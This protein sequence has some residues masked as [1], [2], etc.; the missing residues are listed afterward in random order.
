MGNYAS[1]RQKVGYAEL[2]DSIPGSLVSE[3]DFELF[4]SL[5]RVE[6][7]RTISTLLHPS[8]SQLFF[9]VISGEVH[10]HITSLDV[11]NTSIPAVVFKPGETIHF[12]NMQL[13]N[14]NVSSPFDFGECLKNGNIK[15][16]LHFKSI[17]NSIA[18]VIGMD[19]TGLDEFLISASNNIHALN[20]FLGLR[21]S[22][23]PQKSPFFKTIT[24]E[25]MT[26]FGPLMKVRLSHTGKMISPF[27]ADMAVQ[28][29]RI[30]TDL[31]PKSRKEP[32]GEYCVSAG[33][34][35]SLFCFC[36]CLCGVDQ[37]D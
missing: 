20:S 3:Q 12:F 17:G 34:R 7:V 2:R 29:Q 37:I 31:S 30:R 15:L 21:I 11:K 35:I 24:P 26:I 1:K 23:F 16:A 32:L 4:Y 22:E 9:V 33:V 19:A 10:V 27:T 36:R 8:N 13:K 6:S 14:N 25:Q 18:R 28:C 5:C